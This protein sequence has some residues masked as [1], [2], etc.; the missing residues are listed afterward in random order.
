M[1]SQ[2][3]LCLLQDRTKISQSKLIGVL[4]DKLKPKEAEFRRLS[5]L[6]EDLDL[7][8]KTATLQNDNYR[9]QVEGIERKL[10]M[11]TKDLRIKSREVNIKEDEV[12]R[13]EKELQDIVNVSDNF[14]EVHRRLIMLSKNQSGL[15]QDKQIN[16]SKITMRM[17]DILR[18][19]IKSK[20]E[21][22][23]R[24]KR[25]HQTRMRKLKRDQIVLEEVSETLCDDFTH[26]DIY[27]S[28]SNNF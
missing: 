16:S 5:D 15:H 9:V 4:K 12:N 11:V 7:K 25:L 23:D 20:Q 27:R 24:H 26:F 19:E 2:F 21:I 8:L 18:K 3:I 14:G 22:L 1:L 13:F 10:Y 28:K 17:T 6:S